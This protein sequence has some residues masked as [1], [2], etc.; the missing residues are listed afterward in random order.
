[1]NILASIMLVVVMLLVVGCAASKATIE[2][3]GPVTEEV[4]ESGFYE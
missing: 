2:S 1:M 4:Y 3:D